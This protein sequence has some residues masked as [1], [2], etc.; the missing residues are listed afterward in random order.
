MADYLLLVFPI[1]IMTILF[2]GS[3][4]AG[5]GEFNEEAW[6]MNQSKAM[7]VFAALMIILHHLA[8]TI[9]DCTRV[10]KGPITIWNSFGILFTS[11]FFFFSGF[12]LYKSYK[13]KENYLDSFLRK[14][15]S[16][17][18]IPFA[19]TNILYLVTV[20][21][22]RVT[23]VVDV[24]TSLFGCTLINNNAWFLVVLFF[25]YVA[26]Y[27][28]FKHSGSERGAILKLTVFAVLMVIG[29]LLLGHDNSQVRGHWFM[30]EW[31]YNT[32][33]IFILGIVVAKHENG[34]KQFLMK[35]YRIILP[36][37]II[38]LVGWYLLEEF[39]LGQFGYY[40]EWE[41]HPGYPEKFISLP[42]QVILCAIFVFLLLHVNLKL[43]YGNRVLTFLGGISFEI[44]LI[45]EMFRVLLPGTPD[46][47]MPDLLYMLLVY[48]LSIVAA[49][50]L[51]IVD[52]YLV[53][54]VADREK[55]SEN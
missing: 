35:H 29:A 11:I 37:L 33:L 48:V 54:R 34:I 17:I 8:Q 9:T 28:C 16:R 41:G 18:L 55:H 23:G 50:I 49:W 42:F 7:Q 40:Q 45:H 3:K 39:M 46:S 1:I 12:G 26:F 21:Y 4:V 30:G 53:K 27:I 2:A 25:L 5:K 52:N 24:I 47:S 15:L 51:A 10:S 14:R 19:I 43:K 36:V 38:M 31:W 22:S 32:T 44:Y 20:S 6:T 13:N